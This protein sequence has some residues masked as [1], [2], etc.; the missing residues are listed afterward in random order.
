VPK[1]TGSK[2]KADALLAPDGGEGGSVPQALGSKEEKRQERREKRKEDYARYLESDAWRKIRAKILERDKCKCRA[3]GKKARDV[4][5][6]RYPATLGKEKLEWLYSLCSP[7]HVQVHRLALKMTL[8][9][10]TYL[11][12]GE[13]PKKRKKFK[14]V[15]LPPEK[16][17]SKKMDRARHRKAVRAKERKLRTQR[18]KLKIEM[19]NDELH[20]I[21]KAN[22]ERREKRLEVEK[23]SERGRA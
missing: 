1:A 14:V 11:V 16:P 18:K 19:L 9:E 6:I 17:L 10:A 23:F 5:H 7:C 15:R 21:Q 2:A 12:L 3:C 20:A 13:E 22:R 4:H 8:R